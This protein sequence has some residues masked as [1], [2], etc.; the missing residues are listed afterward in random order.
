MSM[1]AKRLFGEGTLYALANVAP[2][3]TTILVMPLVTRIL[4]KDEYSVIA[5]SITLYQAG[6]ILL[7]LGLS[8]VV[9]RNALIERSGFAGA[10]GLL[11]VSTCLAVV[12]GACLIGL[13]P[14]IS[15]VL[16]PDQSWKILVAPV[17]SSIGLTAMMS[18]QSFMRAQRRVGM[19]V[20]VGG[21][22]SIAAPIAGLASLNTFG[23]QAGSYLF[24]VATVHLLMGLTAIGLCIRQFR[25]IISVEATVSALKIGLPTLPHQASG[26]LLNVAIVGIAGRIGTPGDS[27][28]LQIALVLGTTTILMMSAFNSSW[29]PLIYGESPVNRPK[30]LEATSRLAVL[31]SALLVF[32]FLVMI[33]FVF[34]FVA[35]PVATNSGPTAAGVIALAAP[36]MTMYL[37]N[38]HLVFASGRTGALAFSTPSALVASLLVVWMATHLIQ[39]PLIALSFAVPV[40]Y[41]CQWIAATILRK[42]S[43]YKVAKL[44]KPGSMALGSVAVALIAI[45]SGSQLSVAI[46]GIGLIAVALSARTILSDVKRMELNGP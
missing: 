13:L 39:P 23:L 29:A 46:G 24:A 5:V 36:I 6:L 31:L 40:F 19:F 18:A 43:G 42:R 16:L 45:A 26:A 15:G 3:V 1:L 22:S 7:G 32:G 12:F 33:P 8:S 11:I 30:V 17:I 38:I 44:W 37:A 28:E 21:V 2:M 27:A 25:P 34:R 10:A 35:G 9:T 41:S 14:I 4:G 20:V